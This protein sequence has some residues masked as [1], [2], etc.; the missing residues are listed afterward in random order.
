[1]VQKAENEKGKL[2][3]G[4]IGLLNGGLGKYPM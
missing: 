1:V 3:N 4:G 2:L